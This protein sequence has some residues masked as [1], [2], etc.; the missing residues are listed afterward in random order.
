LQKELLYDELEKQ[1]LVH[2]VSLDNEHAVKKTKTLMVRLREGKK[3]QESSIDFM[4]FLVHDFLDYAQIK[5][6]KFRK[7]CKPF[8]I[9]DTVKRVM[10]IQ[11]KKADDQGL[12]LFATFENIG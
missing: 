7:Q 11:Q 10:S 9:V 4:I 6:N 1:V 8:N 3:V 2:G 5:A 12:E